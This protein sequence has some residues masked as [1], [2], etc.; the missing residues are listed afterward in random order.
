MVAA[1]GKF[2]DKISLRE[3]LLDYRTAFASSINGT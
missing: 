3:A 1:L 2:M